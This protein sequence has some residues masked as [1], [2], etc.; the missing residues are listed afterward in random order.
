MH[1][2][3]AIYG[4][5]DAGG[6]RFLAR[7]PGFLDDWLPHAQQLCTSFGDR[8]A[9]VACPHAL[10]ARPFDKHHVA[11]V[12]V[13]DQGLDDAGRP[14]ALG[15]HLLLVPMDLYRALG[16]DP[17]LIAQHF[18][19]AW[20][21][22]GELSALTWDAPPPSPRSVAEVAHVL[23]VPDSATL[24]GG[25]QALVDGGRIVFERPKPDPE[26]VRS[27]WMLLP[28]S[29]RWE[30]WPATFAFANTLQFDVVVL[31]RVDPVALPGYLLEAHAG[32]YPPGR[33][34]HALQTAAEAGD[35][36]EIDRLF[37]RRSSSETR[38]LALTLVVIA[39]LLPLAVNWLIPGPPPAAPPTRRTT[40][41]LDLPP[42]DKC[43]ELSDDERR[44]LT[45]KLR[46]VADQVGATVAEEA[47]PEDL[48][49][50]IDAKLGTPDRARD[51][52]PLDKYGA[53]QRR[54]R[55]LLWKHNVLKDREPRLNTVELAERLEAKLKANPPRKE[56]P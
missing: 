28:T 35:Q 8:P 36:P 10:F 44:N 24:L 54:L 33:Y 38:R 22:R 55:A 12:Q 43:P 30:R 32:D 7:S 46:E 52:G 50:A 49:Q 40:T 14:G 42:P 48:V 3:Q 27:L 5:Q 25:V 34:E 2:E 23:D 37:A 26:M 11:V 41:E 1:I 4:G 53:I 29:T 17:F 16:G 13:A 31:P 56:S 21:A 39:L 18:P 20:Q 45:A 9:G 19:P 6:Y 51:P 47:T 15:F